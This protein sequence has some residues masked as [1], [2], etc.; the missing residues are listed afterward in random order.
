TYGIIVYQEQIMRIAAKMAGF[1][2]GQADILRRAVSKKKRDVLDQQR[3]NFVEGC[4]RQGYTDEIGHKVYDLILRF[5]DY[6]FIRSHAAAYAVLAY[7]TAYLKANYPLYYMAA[8]L[9]TVMGNHSKM[10]EYVEA[11]R[12]SGIS[13]LHPD[14]NESERTFA[15]REGAIRMGLAAVKNVG[16]HAITDILKERRKKPYRDLFDFC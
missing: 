5:A 2:L 3:K 4:V 11:C 7:E 14:I 10:A 15:V 1:N 16:S 9:T 13:V 6:G 8:L 12:Q